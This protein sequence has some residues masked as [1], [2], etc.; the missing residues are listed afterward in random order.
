MKNALIHVAREVDFQRPPKDSDPGNTPRSPSSRVVGVSFWLPPNPASE[1]ETWSSYFHSWVLS[2]RQVL[3]NIRFLGHGGLVVKRYRIWKAAQEKAQSVLWT[4]P[5]GYYFCNA[6]SILPGHQG[7]GIGR[8]LMEVV[9]DKADREGMPCYLESSKDVPNVRIY[10]RLGFKLMRD[11]ECDDD[12]VVCKV[13]S[14]A[15]LPYPLS[16]PLLTVDSC[17]AWYENQ[18]SPID[19]DG[20]K[21][22]ISAVGSGGGQTD[23]GFFPILPS[24]LILY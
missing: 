10:Q 24:R 14:P 5:R 8:K 13:R 22:K 4:D 16:H 19:R 6:I 7:K 15:W 20:G 21:R 1:A 23:D 12:G 2:V 3:T 17:T 18:S 9:I 11:M